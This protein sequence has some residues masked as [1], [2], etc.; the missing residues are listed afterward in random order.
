MDISEPAVRMVR[1]LQ[2]DLHSPVRREIRHLPKAT[3]VE[4]MKGILEEVLEEP[5]AKKKKKKKLVFAII[6]PHDAEFVKGM[7]GEQREDVRF[8]TQKWSDIIMAQASVKDK[9]SE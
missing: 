3:S 7:F 8:Q 2:D 9:A 6:V 1:L 5:S 4:E